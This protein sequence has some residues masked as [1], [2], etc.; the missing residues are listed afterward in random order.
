MPELTRIYRTQDGR[1]D[2]TFRFTSRPWTS[3]VRVYIENMPS[4]GNRATDGHSTHRYTD[5]R[6]QRYI[7]FEPAP[8]DMTSAF[9]IAKAWAE[10]TWNYIK[11]GTSF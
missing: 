11:T 3:A 8:T 2:F 1:S 6:G 5:P 9:N 7:C 4:Y 10:K